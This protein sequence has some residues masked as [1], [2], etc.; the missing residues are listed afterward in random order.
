MIF[1]DNNGID[2]WFPTSIYYAKNFLS[3]T[4]NKKM[5][6]EA[7]R[8]KSFSPNGG[9]HWNCNV[10]TTFETC[11]LHTNDKFF[12]LFEKIKQHVHH[13]SQAH[14]DESEYE[15]VGSW[16]N[17]NGKD[18]FQEEHVHANS[19]F[20]VIYYLKAPDGSGKTV[21]RDGK[22]PDMYPL[23]NITKR[24]D[25]SFETTQYEPEAGK[26]LIFRSSTPHLVQQGTNNED[27]ITISANFA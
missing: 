3:Y 9:K 10:Y 25:I 24:N 15:C 5:I 18:S 7:Y 12:M 8:I 2:F 20:S 26:L 1:K 17:I 21:F 4:E 22:P 23:K 27:R 6:D 16:L 19:I 11:E 14:G 13:F